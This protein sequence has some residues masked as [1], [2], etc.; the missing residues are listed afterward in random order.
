MARRCGFC[1]GRGHDRRTCEKLAKVA[2]ENPDGYWA[3]E[4]ERIE[5]NKK[6]VRRCSWCNEPGHTKRT[7]P[8]LKAAIAREE[9]KA[10]V[11]NK[12]FIDKLKESGLGA[13]S[14]L[15]ITTPSQ[16]GVASSRINWINDQVKSFGGM[17]LVMGFV[18]TECVSRGAFNSCMIIRG[19]TGL[20]R[21]VALP[22]HIATQFYQY[23]WKDYLQFEIVGKVSD[24][25]V[26]TSFSQNWH[27]GT[28]GARAALG[29]DKLVFSQK[30]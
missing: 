20:R 29:L 25:Q 18:E 27:Q 4:K 14:L 17:A 26:A 5:K 10:R 12:T 1:S 16:D 8:D 19:A 13:G 6:T 3:R 28:P 15:R 21:R 2:K 9:G 23:A 22:Y 30:S 7:C 24:Y 11:W